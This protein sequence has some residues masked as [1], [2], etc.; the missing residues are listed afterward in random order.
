MRTEPPEALRVLNSRLFGSATPTAE[1]TS[2]A[3]R[4]ARRKPGKS[5]P[6]VIAR[7]KPEKARE[8]NGADD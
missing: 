6:E 5:S 2:E 3:S 8:R 7:E 1:G 4:H